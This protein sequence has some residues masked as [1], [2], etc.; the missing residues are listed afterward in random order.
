RLPSQPVDGPARCDLLPA[1][2]V[3]ASAERPARLD[4]EVA[5]LGGEAMRT[6]EEP[7][8][9]DDPASDT[10][11][12][13]DEEHVR[14]PSARPEPELTPRRDVGVVVEETRK[15]GRRRAVRRELA[16]ALGQL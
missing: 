2:S 16:V 3:A 12:H 10:S 11:A 6:S 8:A 15:S 9:G 1:P 7:P 4:D 5:H 13:R 14:R